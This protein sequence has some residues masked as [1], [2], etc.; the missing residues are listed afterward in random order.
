M[1]TGL[2]RSGTGLGRIRS[3]ISGPWYFDARIIALVATILG[4][5][6][7]AATVPRIDFHADEA[8][9]LQGIPLNVSNDSGLVFHLAY[10]AVSM[11]EPTP[12][13][14]RYVSLLFGGLLIFAL[15][16]T[17]QI[18]APQHQCLLGMSIPLVLVVSYQGIFTIVRVRPEI[19][20]CAIA[21]V[22]IWSIASLH[23]QLTKRGLVMLY[24]SLFCL[25][26]NHVLSLFPCFFLALYIAAFMRERL[27]WRG[28]LAA[29][30][31]LG[32]GVIVN[33][34][35]RSLLVM[36]EVRYI[37]SLFGG[38]SG[39]RLPVGVFLRNVFWDSP[40]FLNDSAAY[41]NF[42]MNVTPFDRVAWLSHCMIATFLWAAALALPALARTQ[43][44]VFAFS[45]PL[46][47]LGL[48]YVSNYY[49]PTYAPILAI[50]ATVSFG[51][52]MA[53]SQR[54]NP[55]NWIA[56]A[57]VGVSFCNGISFLGTRVLNHGVASF[58][59]VEAELREMVTGLPPDS[60]I[61]VAERFQ[62]VANE[63]SGRV[64]IL[65]KDEIDSRVDYVIL[66]N[67]D[68]DMYRFVPD[69]ETRRAEII[70]F[71]DAAKPLKR[72]AL[73]VYRGD[74]LL[75]GANSADALAAVQGSWFFRNSTAY[76]VTVLQRGNASV[77]MAKGL[78]AESDSQ[79]ER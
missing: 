78:G 23:K 71:K 10:L 4:C 18:S 73:S 24:L 68:F 35:C 13:A 22:A 2:V 20:W 17:L 27:G 30:G 9:Y 57:V 50:Y 5:L 39:Q 74:T 43:R 63:Y 47:T 53:T 49:N 76:T 55:R 37:P 16:R 65:F 38:V 21:A 31:V 40:H 52:V 51:F 29:F 1:S 66:D 72:R 79:I 62:S 48:F 25:P 41:P 75:S 6:F 45:V 42:W 8:I 19:S 7:L 56:A 28:S 67:Y 59:A 64:T 54:S 33:S 12:L 32:L 3:G 70:A 11:G 36:G 14:A 44:Q 77:Q 61:A 15:T 46:A 26:M 34:S 58:F 60:A 69:Y